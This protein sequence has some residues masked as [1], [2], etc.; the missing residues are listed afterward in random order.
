MRKF[1]KGR[2][3][4]LEKGP[5]IALLR[6]LANN[7]FLY[8]KIK[9]SEARA[10]ELRSIAEKMIT[11]AKRAGIADRK[12]L[13]CDLSV[14]ITKKLVEKIAPLYKER[15]GGYTRITRL[16]NRNS[17]GSQMVIIELVK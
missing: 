2:K 3:L 14:E 10:K 13:N 16:G 9:T 7:F 4:S 8:E 6:K 1:N 15:H 17:D 11:K 12:A 5:R